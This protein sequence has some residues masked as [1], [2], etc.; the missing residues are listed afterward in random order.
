MLT[1]CLPV[2]IESRLEALASLS[3]RTKTDLA[4]AA[5]L[6][7]IDNLEDFYLAEQRLSDVRAGH[8]ETVSLEVLE[9]QYAAKD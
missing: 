9:Q 2:E 7:H 8:S 5:I 4:H 3:G 1:I 6:E